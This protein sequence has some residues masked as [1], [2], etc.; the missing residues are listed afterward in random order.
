MGQGNLTPIS[1]SNL[2]IHPHFT[3]FI[4]GF[5]RFTPAYSQFTPT[6]SRFYLIF[7]LRNKSGAEQQSNVSLNIASSNWKQIKVANGLLMKI[8]SCL[9]PTHMFKLMKVMDLVG[10]QLLIMYLVEHQINVNTDTKNQLI[11]RY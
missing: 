5:T 7:R 4:P 9:T 11:Q 1:N 8:K 3:L 10:M 6:H 2:R